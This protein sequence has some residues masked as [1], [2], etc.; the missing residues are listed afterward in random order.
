[1]EGYLSHNI[2]SCHCIQGFLI[3]NTNKIVQVQKIHL[4]HTIYIELLEHMIYIL[5]NCQYF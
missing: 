5:L 2:W 3:I 4:D 1:M